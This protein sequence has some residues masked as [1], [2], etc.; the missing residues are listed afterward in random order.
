[1]FKLFQNGNV[2]QPDFSIKKTDIL[3]Q[4]DIIYDLI[5]PGTEPLKPVDSCLD[6]SDHYVFPGLINAHDHL[7]DT[8]WAPLGETPQ[9]NWYDWDKTVKSSPDYKLMQR[10]SV[11]DLYIIGMYKNV[12]SGATTVVD[13]FPA[14]VS[15]TFAGHPLVTLLEH[16]YLS[17]SVS[18]RQLQWGRN[19]VEQFKQARSILPFILHIGE[20]TAKEIREELETLSRM[21]ALEKNTVLV[22]ACHLEEPELQLVAQK[23]AAIVW[24]PGSSERIFGRQPDINKILELGIPLTIGTDSSITGSGNILNEL[25]LAAEHIEKTCSDKLEAQDLLSMVTIDA[26]RIF[27]IEKSK[28]SISAGKSADFLIFKGNEETDPFSSLLDLNPESFSMVVHKGDMIIGND[29]FRRMSAID[30][31]QYS[32]I[33]IN[34]VTKLLLGHPIQLLQRIRHKLGKDVVFPFFNVSSDEY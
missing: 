32:E 2:L 27:G 20:G 18:E 19:T 9:E 13:H 6:I 26:A 33:K 3:V 29:E 31:S 23:G 15:A 28:G 12:I 7:I 8:C 5:E 1:M 4:D 25:R 30:F 21:G 34:G 17:H 16:F 10:L 24:L 11:T 22:N 14:E